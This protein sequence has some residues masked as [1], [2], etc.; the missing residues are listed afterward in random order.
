MKNDEIVSRSFTESIQA[1]QG[2]L[3]PENVSKT[4]ISAELVAASFRKG[5][6]LIIA[7]NGGSAADAQ[8]LAAEF[9]NRFEIERPPLPALAITTDS[10][11]LTSIG[12]DYSF[13][14]V[15]SK[16]LLALG[17]PDDVFLAITTSG[18][19]QNILKAIEAAETIGMKVIILTGKGGGLLSGKGDVFVNVDAR[20]TARIQEVHITFGHVVCELVDHMLFQKV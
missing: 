17:K 13:D 20:R 16:Q 14:Q 9:I 6:K 2:F 5:G 18:N 7:G 11:D 10:S 4:V 3:T 1:K 15:F 19:S 12:N 8:H